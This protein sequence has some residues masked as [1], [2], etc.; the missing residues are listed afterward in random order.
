MS[1][2]G[3]VIGHC[4]MCSKPIPDDHPYAWCSECGTSLPPEV[5]ATLAKPNPPPSPSAP[6]RNQGVPLI[7]EG[8][9]VACPICR[10]DRYNL[11]RRVMPSAAA[12]FFD[13]EWASPSA[14]TYICL[15]CGHV[16]WFMR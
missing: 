7:V 8:T 5:K 13:V 11:K 3:Q 15:R 12:A 14:E 10:H 6:P 1:D 4:T 9:P 16:M 2:T